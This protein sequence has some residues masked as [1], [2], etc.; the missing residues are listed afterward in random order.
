[1]STVKRLFVVL[2][3][4][5]LLFIVDSILKGTIYNWTN[6]FG[7]FQSWESYFFK[8][9][10]ELDANLPTGFDDDVLQQQP[11]HINIIAIILWNLFLVLGL[12]AH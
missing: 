1:M 5:P 6:S 9:T 3:R 12:L 4:L 7:D 10:D 11:Y 2:G 8:T